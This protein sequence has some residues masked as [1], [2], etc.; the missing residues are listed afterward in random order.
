METEKVALDNKRIQ[1][2]I[3]A[4]LDPDTV[5]CIMKSQYNNYLITKENI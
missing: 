2:L 3:V 4:G 1:A 5:K